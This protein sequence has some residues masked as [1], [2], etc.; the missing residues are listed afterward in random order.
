MPVVV[1]NIERTP[2]EDIAALAKY[3]VATIHAAQGRTGP[4]ASY[5]R[6]IYA[7][8]A[9]A[10]NAVTVSI[11]PAISRLAPR[12]WRAAWT[13]CSIASP[14]IGLRPA[15]QMNPVGRKP[16]ADPTHGQADRP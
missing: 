12:L 3:G 2:L 15:R 1:Q 10:G 13:A 14:A 9:A 16:G 5:M 6:P 4:L 8:A 7:G 11:P